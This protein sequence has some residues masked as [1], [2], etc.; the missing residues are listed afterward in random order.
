MVHIWYMGREQV[1]DVKEHQSID[2]WL[3]KQHEMHWRG[4]VSNKYVFNLLYACGL[5][6]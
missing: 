3:C 6:S 1:A 2:L 4:S 5:L